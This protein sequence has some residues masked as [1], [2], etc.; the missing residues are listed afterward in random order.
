MTVLLLS[1][2]GCLSD[3]VAAVSHP[4]ETMRDTPK[5]CVG[6]TWDPTDSYINL[7]NQSIL[8]ELPDYRPYGSEPICVHHHN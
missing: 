6:E 4:E 2:I 1:G 8:G 5:T 3:T 7:E